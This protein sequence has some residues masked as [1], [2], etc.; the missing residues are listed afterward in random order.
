MT[1]G[2]IIFEYRKKAGLTQEELADRLGV[3]RQAVSKWEQD[4]AFPENGEDPRTVQT[5]LRFRRRAAVRQKERGRRFRARGSVARGRGP[6]GP[7]GCG[8]C[9]RG[10]RRTA[11]RDRTDGT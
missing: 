2:E 3:S 9:D 4:A 1:T 6:R 5:L 11:A 8:I 7:L 10:G